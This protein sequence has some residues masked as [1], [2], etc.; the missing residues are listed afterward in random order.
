MILLTAAVGQE[1]GFWR[2]RPNVKTLLT[3][4]G[5]VEAAAAVARELARAPYRCV[6]NAG[7]AGAFEGAAGVGDAVVV[8][9]E[10]MEIT[11][12][13]GQPIRLP[14]GAAIPER[15]RSHDRLVRALGAA[16]FPALRGI[17]VSQ[18][19]TTEATAARLA[20]LGAQVESTEGFAV[21]RAA[22]LAGVAAVELRGISNRVGDR[23]M[24]AWNFQAGVDALARIVTAFFDL[25]EIAVEPVA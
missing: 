17:T 11:L 8:A 24:S 12:E 1:L 13:S 23:T 4:V 3:G 22:A 14:E 10:T 6:V 18:V 15:A 5:P 9:E 20:A 25:G 21:L 7:I 2:A 19:T 16:G